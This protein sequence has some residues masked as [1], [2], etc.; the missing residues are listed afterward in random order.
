MLHGVLQANG[1]LACPQHTILQG[2]CV[3]SR[4]NAGA[5]CKT[6]AGCVAVGV[7]SD[8]GWNKAFPGSAQLGSAPLVSSSAGFD[9]ST[10]VTYTVPPAA[11]AAA[12]AAATPTTA[13]AAATVAAAAA[14]ATSAEVLVSELSGSVWQIISSCSME[15]CTLGEDG[16]VLAQQNP[17]LELALAKRVLA[18]AAQYSAVLGVDREEGGLWAAISDGLAHFPI[19]TTTTTTTTPPPTPTA[20]AASSTSPAS[21]SSIAESSAAAATKLAG[22]GWVFAESNVTSASAFGANAWYPVDYYAAIHP[23]AG[24]GLDTRHSDPALFQIA[25]NTV[26]KLNAQTGWRPESGAQMDWIAAVR[27]GWNA[28]EFVLAAGAALSAGGEHVT[29]CPHPLRFWLTRE[30]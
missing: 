12:A 16:T 21:S 15:L 23:G 17:T 2:G 7:T 10:W 24:V 14:A 26:S 22:A 28:T 20:P 19:T 11:V 3:V 6:I 29:N 30:Y 1:T 8:D 9:V 4:E 27:L 5:L 25:V 13:P 18:S